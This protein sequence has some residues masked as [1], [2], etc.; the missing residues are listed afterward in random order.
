MRLVGIMAGER[1]ISPPK[2]WADR[3]FSY[4]SENFPKMQIWA[5]KPPFWDSL[6]FL[7]ICNLLCQKCS[8]YVGELQRPLNL[9][10]NAQ[11]RFANV[12]LSIIIMFL[13]VL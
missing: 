6:K 2:F 5:E 9:L 8:A 7:S 1:A 3:K 13:T 11:R 10:F 12:G 4:L